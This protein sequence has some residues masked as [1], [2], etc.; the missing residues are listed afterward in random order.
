MRREVTKSSVFR[1]IFAWMLVG[2]LVPLTLFILYTA[3]RGESSA[4]GT[5]SIWPFY[6]GAVLIAGATAYYVARRL[7]LPLRALERGAREIA[8]GRFEHRIPVESADEI[9]NLARLFNYMTTELHR[10]N[11]LNISRIITERN[12]NEAIL[13]NLADGVIVT[14]LHGNVM[15]LSSVAEQWLGVKEDEARGKPLGELWRNRQLLRLI[16]QIARNPEAKSLAVE[17]VDRPRSG[18][19]LR[20][21]ECKAAPVLTAERERIGVVTIVRDVTREREVDRMK[22]ELV[23]MVAHE[24]RSPLTSIRGFSELLMDPDLDRDQVREF[25]S[26]IHEETSRLSELVNK[27]LDIS[28]L[29]SGKLQPQKEDLDLAEV[30]TSVVGSHGSLAQEKNI[31]VE[32][33]HRDGLPTIRADRQMMTQLVLNLFSN[34][35]KYSPA[36]SRVRLDV[37]K[38]GRELVLSVEDEGYGIPKKDLPHIF[39]KFY[40]ASNV[41]SSE[42][43][44]Q[45]SGLGL[46]LVQRIVQ[47]HGGRIRVQ[48]EVGKGTTFRVYF[49]LTEG[50]GRKPRRVRQE[51]GST[52]RDTTE[53]VDGRQRLH[54]SR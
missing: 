46:A 9:G 29:E 11:E 2:T 42:N 50:H 31:T 41:D 26:I 13:R 1:R 53:R 15:A 21:F 4:L 17:I 34:A 7:V 48:S 5:G 14:D 32:W 37:H 22:T 35:V 24:L 28:R 45:G 27:F 3:W 47:M 30:V 20:T 23:S 16:R 12:K 25:A 18:W 36:G 33:E 39:N 6:F 38:R 44:A 54:P 43:G 10:L 49:P 40:R 51:E 19:Q 52:A 8:R